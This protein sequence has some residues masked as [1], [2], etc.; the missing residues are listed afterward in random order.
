VTV[1][2]RRRFPSAGV[3]WR[4]GV[5]VTAN[6]TLTREEGV[7]VTVAAG[8]SISA[9]IAGRDPTTDLAIL[10]IQDGESALPQMGSSASAKVGQLALALGRVDGV[11]R[12]SLVGVGLTGGAWRTWYGGEI[13][14][15][16]RLD[17]ELHPTLSGGPLVDAQGRL[18]GLNTAG[19]SRIVGTT[20]PAETVDRIVGAL[21][22]KGFIGR[23]YV[24]LGLYS[25]P[26]PSTAQGGRAPKAAGGSANC[27]IVLNVEPNG[28]AAKAGVL[29]GDLITA[30]DGTP[31]HDTDDLQK[32]LSGERVGKAI[33]TSIIRGGTP[34]ELSITVA[35]RP[36]LQ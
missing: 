16:I 25:I 35:E 22:E 17:R 12:A 30:A 11:P 29:V 18:L 14:R 36:R 13:E 33:K 3:H 1:H 28:P 5:V 8:G 24:G 34:V 21:L 2:G 26:Y 15:L 23:G 4:K 31:V 20:I 9:T 19:L 7:T 6:H 27:L 10:K 32:V